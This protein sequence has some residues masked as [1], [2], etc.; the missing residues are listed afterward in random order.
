MKENSL[1][2]VKKGNG[3]YDTYPLGKI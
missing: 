2:L 1:T 3:W